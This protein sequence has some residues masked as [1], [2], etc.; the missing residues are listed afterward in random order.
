MSTIYALYLL[1]PSLVLSLFLT[2]THCMFS[3]DALDPCMLALLRAEVRMEDAAAGR[4]A[5]EHAVQVRFLSVKANASRGQC[6]GTRSILSIALDV[7]HLQ[8]VS[9]SWPL[10]V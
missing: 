5:R 4:L 2:H 1:F 3:S 9:I 7:C 6:Q 10:L 8:N